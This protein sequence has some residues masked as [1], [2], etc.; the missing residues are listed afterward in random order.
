MVDESLLA[1]LNQK[2]EEAGRQ[3]NERLL[4]DLLEYNENEN[5]FSEKETKILIQAIDNCKILDPACGSGAFPMGIL[6]KL[7]HILHKLD[8]HNERWKE[9]QIAKASKIDDPTIR[10][11]AIKDIEDTFSSNELDYGRKLYLIENSIYGVD[12]QP[13][14][15]QIAKLRFFISLT[16]DQ[17]KQPAKENLGIRSLPNLETKFVAA[18]T[19]IELDKADNMG[20]FK[21]SDI[22]KLEDE[23]TELRHQYF[24]SRTRKEKLQFQKKDKK[25]RQ[26]IA[27][28]LVNDGWGRQCC[29]SNSRI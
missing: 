10:Q 23:L 1:Y 25:L 14:A 3:D 17:K 22:I 4:R 5:S 12:I 20:L 8:P 18:N 19:L 16:I 21:S 26:E 7:V 11:H 27:R 24:N 2:L 15:V 9:R 6:H 28:L 29:E 13:I